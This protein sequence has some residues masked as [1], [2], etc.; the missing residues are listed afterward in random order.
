VKRASGSSNAR[1]QGRRVLPRR[2]SA[3]A[4]GSAWTSGPPLFECATPLSPISPDRAAQWRPQSDEQREHA[5]LAA[6]HPEASR[7]TQLVRGIERKRD[8]L[9]KLP[10]RLMHQ[11]P[12]DTLTTVRTFQARSTARNTSNVWPFAVTLQRSQA[13]KPIRAPSAS[14][15]T[16]TDRPRR[17]RH[18]LPPKHLRR[19]LGLDRARPTPKHRLEQPQHI[20]LVSI[21]IRSYLSYCVECVRHSSQVLSGQLDPSGIGWAPGSVAGYR[22]GRRS[23]HACP[24]LINT[25]RESKAPVTRPGICT[26]CAPEPPRVCC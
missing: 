10:G 15:T 20:S 6:A 22:R 14:A 1:E 4:T 2:R 17:V 19:I 24:C 18:M 23:P 21:A 7:T 9:W 13:P 26:A 25:K 16:I 12:V 5:Q 3:S 8:I 11:L